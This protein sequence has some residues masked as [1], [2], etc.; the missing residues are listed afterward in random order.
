MMN[1]QN[2][3]IYDNPDRKSNVIIINNYYGN[4]A[5]TAHSDRMSQ[6]MMDSIYMQN[7]IHQ[8]SFMQDEKYTDSIVRQ[9]RMQQQE[10]IQ[11]QTRQQAMMDSAFFLEKRDSITRVTKDSLQLKRKQLDTL[12]RS[13][14]QLQQQI[15]STNDAGAI[16]Q[17]RRL[18][19]N[20]AYMDS[21]VATSAYSD[22]AMLQRKKKENPV[23]DTIVI[24]NAEPVTNRRVTPTNRAMQDEQERRLRYEIS[25]QQPQQ[26]DLYRKYSGQA[27]ALSN[28]INRLSDRLNN[29]DR[30]YRD[31]T[32]YVPVAVPK[33]YE[34]ERLV[35]VP[36][37]ANNAALKQR[38]TMYVR[39]TV[40]LTVVSN[41]ATDTLTR[42]AMKSNAATPEK[43]TEAPVFD[44]ST[45]PA[46]II[47]FDVSKWLVQPIYMGRLRY[48]AGLL[49]KDS[50]LSV[51]VTGHT[52]PT[53]PKEVNEKLSLR[54]A[55]AVADILKNNGVKGKQIKITAYAS[56]D[57]AV[58]G[59]TK[60]DNRQNR[61]VEVKIL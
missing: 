6:R 42:I 38:D 21:V 30:Y 8:R 22:T 20:D 53:G 58:A 31:Q 34:R 9:D 19:D 46:E 32:T 16:L 61:R 1:Y 41:S 36:A 13:M 28:D 47:L 39:D 43:T 29:P 37:S 49:Q 55:K 25:R 4:D 15:D 51:A 17:Q 40:F 3:N 52:D 2:G 57:P 26:D 27:A 48:V 18:E 56:A 24:T 59:N 14:Q 11:M 10:L 60:A 44:F 54:R 5:K 35:H 23:T 50:S 7:M 45:L 12:I 33:T